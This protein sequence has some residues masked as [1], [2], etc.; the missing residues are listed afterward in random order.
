MARSEQTGSSAWRQATCTSASGACRE[1]DEPVCS[2]RAT[3]DGPVDAIYQALDRATGEPHDLVD[4]TIEAVSEGSGA[5]GEVGV[6]VR[7]GE[8][9]FSGRA[10]DTDVLQASAQAYL[11]AL[12]RLAAFH[13]DEQ[14][15]EF[16]TEGI[17]ETF[18]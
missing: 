13:T 5:Q 18:A 12:N 2:E 1:G 6:T 7:Y 3:G 15:V 9:T 17:M 10:T 16:V 14:S 4:Y 8:D 11:D